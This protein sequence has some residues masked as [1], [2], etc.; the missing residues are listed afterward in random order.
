MPNTPI[1]IEPC[2]AALGAE[3]R[4]ANLHEPDTAT[5]DTLRQALVTHQVLFFEPHE[6]AV[7]EHQALAAAFGEIAP[8]DELPLVDD[9]YDVIHL[10]TGEKAPTAEWWHADVTCAPAP[11]MGSLLHMQITPDRGGA[12]HFASMTRAWEALSEP[13][14]QRLEGLTARHDSWW[15]PL[16]SSIHP[17]VRTHPESGRKLIFVNYIFT[18]QIV[19]LPEDESDALLQELFD[20]TAREEFSVRHEWSPFELALW[21][22]RATHHRVDNDFGEAR[23]RIHRVTIQGDR[24]Y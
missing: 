16:Q 3:V 20:H 8:H 2:D 17:V 5:I 7:H 15:Q 19:E 12:T 23:R 6:L 10:D 22:N 4:G 14:K 21:D 18:K 13:M 1:Q 9:E 24:P 11:P